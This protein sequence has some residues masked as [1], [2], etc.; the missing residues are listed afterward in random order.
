[1]YDDKFDRRPDENPEEPVNQEGLG[2]QENAAGPADPVRPESCAEPALSES[3][4]GPGDPAGAETPSEPEGAEEHE[5]PEAAEDQAESRPELELPEIP[6]AQPAVPSAA[7]YEPP[8]FEPRESRKSGRGRAWRLIAGAVALVMLSA[9]VGSGTTYYLVKEQLAAQPANY[10]QTAPPSVLQPVSQTVAEVGAS[11]IPEI[12]RRVSPAVVS[13]D[14]EA[15]RGF[16]RTS[17][18]GSGFVVDPEGYILTNYHVIDD[19]RSIQVKFYDGTI[20]AGEVVGTDPYQDLA[21]VKVDP[22]DRSLVPVT[23]GDSDA[24]QVG[25]LAVAIG[26]PFGQE[27]TMTAGI[28]SAVD[29][30]V[31]GQQPILHSW[32]DSD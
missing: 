24:V 32:S 25:E 4:G 29:R 5:M 23:L 13:V 30:Q 17:G 7:L 19:A 2:Q 20:L 8:R 26:S 10:Q 27:F 21:V 28:I 22:G 11:V 14:V 18:S 16:Y 31:R 3:P 9:A 12:Y 1:M 6:E 15:G